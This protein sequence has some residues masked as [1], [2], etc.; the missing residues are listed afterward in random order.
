M[1]PFFIFF[2]VVRFVLAVCLVVSVDLVEG[3][4]SLWQC[5]WW[6][7][8][9]W[10]NSYVR[11]GSLPGGVYRFGGRVTFARHVWLNSAL[12]YANVQ[13]GVSLPPL[14]S[15]LPASNLAAARFPRLHLLASGRPGYG[16]LPFPPSA[17]HPC[18]ADLARQLRLGDVDAGHNPTADIFVFSVRAYWRFFMPDLARQLRLGD[19]DAGPGPVT[20]TT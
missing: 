6:C 11:F 20:V 3:L 9:I 15:P 14:Q 8:W 18:G 19:V 16:I 13:R 7:L 5:A 10:W 17:P 12:M 4:R 2:N 1:F